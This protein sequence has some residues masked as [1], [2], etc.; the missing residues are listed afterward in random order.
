VELLQG[1]YEVTLAV[2]STLSTQSIL[3]LI[4]EQARLLLN[5]S[6]ALTSFTEEGEWAQALVSVSSALSRPDANLLDV[7]HLFKEQLEGLRH[8]YES[9]QRQS[10]P[11]YWLE[12]PL[13]ERD[14]REVGLVELTSGEGEAFTEEDQL[15][16]LQFAQMTSLALSNARRYTQ[17]Q[18]A[19]VSNQLTMQVVERAAQSLQAPLDALS[20]YLETEQKAL[21]F[22]LEQAARGYSLDPLLEERIQ[23][24]QALT[25]YVRRAAATVSQLEDVARL[26]CGEPLTG[27]ETS[28][29][30]LVALVQQTVNTLHTMLSNHQ[31]QFVATPNS[32]FLQGNEARIQQVLTYLVNNAV[33]YSTPGSLIHVKLT[34]KRE[35]DEAIIRVQDQGPGFSLEDQKH[36]F[37]RQYWRERFGQ[38]HGLFLGLYLSRA[39][40]EQLGGHLWLESVLGEGSRFFFSL[41]LRVGHHENA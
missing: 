31:M 29:I 30:D 9:L 27:T 3:A 38:S 7:Q 14:G 26:E 28:L 12:A 8:R 19:L 22:T 6:Y 20:H 4:G 15:V 23:T 24:L 32:I 39:I 1:L 25:E 13:L 11:A 5:A 34:C 17:A 36:L 2:N 41:P 37:D 10:P 33:T 40:I 35:T 18:D 21:H 16:F